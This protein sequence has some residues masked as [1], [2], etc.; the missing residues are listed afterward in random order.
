MAQVSEFLSAVPIKTR[1]LIKPHLTEV[2]LERGATLARP[3]SKLEIAYL[4]IDCVLSVDLQISEGATFCT[5]LI[6]SDGLLGAGMSLDDRV[7]LYG[8]SAITGGSAFVLTMS[9]LR[10]LLLQMPE[11]RKRSLAY[12]QFF[13]AQVQQTAACS[14]LHE[15]PARLGSWLLRLQQHAGSEISLTQNTLA[16]MLG[17]RRTTVTDAALALQKAGAIEYR[18]GDISILS[19]EKVR[20]SSCGCDAEIASH[21][22]RLFQAEFNEE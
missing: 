3:H 21:Y 12:E 1:D 5:G 10:D 22:S 19:G 16:Q 2:K 14:A 9:R 11:F 17:V 18:R 13:L 20:Q 6:G 4:P 15:A 8:V 7:C